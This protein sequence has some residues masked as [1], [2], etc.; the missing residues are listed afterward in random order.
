MKNIILLQL[1]LLIWVF[2]SWSTNLYK[3]VNCDWEAPYKE[4]I[5]HGIGV[6]VVPVSFVTCWLDFTEDKEN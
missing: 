2:A 4:E 5:I 1:L 3:L 6:P